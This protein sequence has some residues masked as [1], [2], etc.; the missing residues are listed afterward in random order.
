MNIWALGPGDL[1]FHKYTLPQG[2]VG[3]QQGLG[4]VGLNK[5]QASLGSEAKGPQE[6]P[7]T[8]RPGKEISLLVDAGL[9]FSGAPKAILLRDSPT[10]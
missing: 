3:A 4:H 7:S 10:C 1:Y 2:D 9:V 8:R 6:V 5:L